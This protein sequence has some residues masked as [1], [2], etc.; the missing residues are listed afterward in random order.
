MVCGLA[1]ALP[2][3]I[4]VPVAEPVAVGEKTTLMKQL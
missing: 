2:V 4:S 1:A 3:T